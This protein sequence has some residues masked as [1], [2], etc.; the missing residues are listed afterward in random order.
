MQQGMSSQAGEK[1]CVF[2][3]TV[4]CTLSKEF[5]VID[6][7]LRCSHPIMHFSHQLQIKRTGFQFSD[8]LMQLCY[9]FN[10]NMTKILEKQRNSNV[11]SKKLNKQRYILNKENTICSV[12]QPPV[13]NDS[14]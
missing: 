4:F 10:C 2:K 7:N 11:N 14:M 9:I 3:N 1:K 13:F 5:Q 8:L 12:S 6:L